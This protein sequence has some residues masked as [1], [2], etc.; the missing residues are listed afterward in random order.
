MFSIVQQQFCIRLSYRL[1]CVG[2]VAAE[3]WHLLG[4]LCSRRN[5]RLNSFEHAVR[6]DDRDPHQDRRQSA[7]QVLGHN[8]KVQVGFCHSSKRRNGDRCA[9]FFSPTYKR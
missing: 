7:R 6:Y 1:S 3:R 8:P 2:R 4:P 9:P 5:S